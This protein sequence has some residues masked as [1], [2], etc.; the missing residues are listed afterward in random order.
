V[1]AGQAVNLTA[2]T[3]DVNGVDLSG[4]DVAVVARFD[5]IYISI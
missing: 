5:L 1:A 4:D 2:N 3:D